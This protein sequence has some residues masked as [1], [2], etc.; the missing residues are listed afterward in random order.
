MT[1][2]HPLI[3]VRQLLD[4]AI[5]NEDTGLF[6]EMI[7]GR[8]LP[9]LGGHP[10]PA[11]IIMQA[12]SIQSFDA[13]YP[14]NVARLTAPLVEQA[15]A[16]L[17]EQMELQKLIVVGKT[18]T[19]CGDVESYIGDE[20]Y[21]YNLFLLSSFLPGEETLFSSIYDYWEQGL[22][23]SVIL[24]G[25]YVRSERQLRQALIYQ[26][27]DQRM[28]K[29][30]LQGLSSDG[31]LRSR[32]NPDQYN[33]VLEAWTGLLWIPPDEAQIEA[34][35]TLS[36]QRIEDG[37]L[38]LSENFGDTPQ[39]P[40]ILTD[41]LSLLGGAFP[42]ESSFWEEN[43]ADRW[44]QWPQPLQDAIFDR[45]PFLDKKPDTDW[46]P[47]EAMNAW[48]SLND[49]EQAIFCGDD[50]Q[51]VNKCYS[52]LIFGRPPEGLTKQD[53]RT[54]L[55]QIFNARF[56][57]EYDASE[58]RQM[59]ND[60]RKSMDDKKISG[61][62][63]DRHVEHKAINRKAALSRV[64]SVLDEVANQ[65]ADGNEARARKFLDELVEE[66][67]REGTEGELIAMTLS[68]AAASAK[69]AGYYELASEFYENAIQQTD[70]DPV[71]HCGLAEVLKA[72]DRFDEAE[73]LYRETITKWPAAVVA[74]T[75]LA[76]VLKA[77]DRFDEAETLYRKTISRWPVNAVAK[78]SLAN[79]LG[80]KN[81]YD[82]ALELIPEPSDAIGLSAKYDL[83]L[84]AMIFMRMDNFDEA[85]RLLNKGLSGAR[86]DK[87]NNIFY[88]SLA[89][90]KNRQ[91]KHDEALKHVECI[92]EGAD[93]VTG[94]IHLHAVAGSKPV[95]QIKTVLQSVTAMPKKSAEI[96]VVDMLVRAYGLGE[97]D[98]YHRASSADNIELSNAEISMMLAA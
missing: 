16:Q 66:Q 88:K 96:K 11:D 73:V 74:R 30:W 94:I 95:E 52:M 48:K 40:D 34:I 77:Q 6:N 50:K 79:L 12:M 18:E 17:S 83:H 22:K 65:L 56:D 37:L 8:H 38:I 3:E 87:R 54:Q 85:E 59:L 33:D 53:F 43:L 26:Q 15:R 32:L 9:L 21:I 68:N 69:E 13:G 55:T 84:R 23:L 45:W 10:E 35:E 91:E 60:E 64:N 41:A 70:N 67:D 78:H 97:N 80:Q 47:D 4:K 19:I 27:T 51:A 98:N 71:P 14:F 39:G 7:M 31:A 61:Q 49:K 92:N 28:E 44:L 57:N 72:Q 58:H 86:N 42:R 20:A 90:L 29:H 82:E 46:I 2:I 25:G 62:K 89:V 5:K 1:A 63:K 24:A 36:M 93:A 81:R 75:G 76:E